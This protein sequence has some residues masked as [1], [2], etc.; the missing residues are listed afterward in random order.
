[1]YDQKAD[2]QIITH[3]GFPNVFSTTE[4]NCWTR[5][6]FS[7]QGAPVWRRVSTVSSLATSPVIN[8]IRETSS[9]RCRAIQ[10]WTSAPLTPPGV[11]MS[12]TM[13]RKFPERSEEHT[14]ELQSRG[15]L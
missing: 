8:T 10:V 15:H 3:C 12:E 6:G 1:I 14:S 7:T 4:I 5:K 9:G 2:F 13:P 11:R